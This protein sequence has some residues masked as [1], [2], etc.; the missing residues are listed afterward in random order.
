MHSSTSGSRK[1]DAPRAIALLLALLVLYC[2]A[3]EIVTRTKFTSISRVQ[4]RISA[5]K[6]AALH[7]QPTALDGSRTVLLVGNSL[8]VHGVQPDHLHQLMGPR[9]YSEVLGIEN[10]QY[11]DW[12]FGL[13]RLFAEGSR[14]SVVVLFLTP[15]QLTSNGIDG[16]YFAHY[17]LRAQDTLELKKRARLDNTMATN[18]LFANGSAW[19][20]S[21]AMIRNWLLEELMPDVE[22]LTSYLPEKAAPLPSADVVVPPSV[23]RLQEIQALCRENGSSFLF[24]IP[25][26]TGSN[27]LQEALRSAA[28]RDGVTVL[29]PVRGGEMAV[30]YFSDGFHLNPQGAAIFTE[31]L[32]TQLIATQIQ[33]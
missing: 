7:L 14:P 8:L 28:A 26:T 16:E 10:T 4:R 2:A 1:L 29:V 5:D 20:G 23:A 18:F 9:Y 3:L 11:L 30:S 6:Q 31:R 19:L 24:V 33:E 15:R 27:E 25:P 13:R 32:G 12:Y 17:M 22:K 21:R